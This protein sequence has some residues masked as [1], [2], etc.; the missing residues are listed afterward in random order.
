MLVS[1]TALNLV[2][3]A[4]LAGVLIQRFRTTR[5]TGYLVLGIPLVLWSVISAPLNWL[6]ESQINRHLQGEAMLWPLSREM[7]V[8]NMVAVFNYAET[9]V[10]AALLVV[11]FLWLARV[12]S[13][14]ESEA[15]PSSRTPEEAA[16]SRAPTDG[17]GRR[18]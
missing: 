8:G 17:P 15:P 13:R 18:K 2:L 6:L 1:I 4:V 5:N 3:L 7:T 9:A 10:R 11:G 14:T 16:P 12:E